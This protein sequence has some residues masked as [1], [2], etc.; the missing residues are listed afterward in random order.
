M[1]IEALCGGEHGDSDG[2]DSEPYLYL[3]HV[4]K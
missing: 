3:V 4:T 1:Q 2:G